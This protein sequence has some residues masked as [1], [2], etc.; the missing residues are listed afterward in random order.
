ENYEN[1]SSAL[2]L[3]F[4]QIEGFS[5]DWWTKKLA[6]AGANGFSSFET[7]I[8][9]TRLPKRALIIL[10]EADCFRSLD[11]DRRESLW[12]VRRLPDDEAL[13]LFAAQFVDDLPSETITPLPLMPLS[14]HTIAD[15]QMM[16]LSLRAHLMQFLRGMFQSEGALSCAELLQA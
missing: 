13:P 14:E 1:G 11:L 5:Q 6:A 3:G 7:F 12:K 2:R 8:R 15:Y 9:R 10:A 16:R 4:R